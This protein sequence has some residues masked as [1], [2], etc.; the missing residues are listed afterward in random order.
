MCIRD[1]VK[2]IKHCTSCHLQCIH[3][4]SCFHEFVCSCMDSCH[5]KQYVQTYSPTLNNR[6]PEERENEDTLVIDILNDGVI[7]E[8]IL[9]EIS[10]TKETEKSVSSKKEKMNLD[11]SA[12]FTEIQENIGTVE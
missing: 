4:N 1:S 6:I 7:L 9:N 11:L 3:C 5:M 2:R 12:E 8:E 10:T